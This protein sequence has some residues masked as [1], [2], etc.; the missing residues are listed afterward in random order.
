[1]IKA[2]ERDERKSVEAIVVRY[3]EKIALMKA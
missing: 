1:M 2:I 3:R